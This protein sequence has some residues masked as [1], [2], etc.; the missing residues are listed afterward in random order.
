MIQV[1][2]P[3]LIEESPKF[4]EKNLLIN[5]KED[6]KYAAIVFAIAPWDFG[7]IYIKARDSLLLNTWLSFLNQLLEPYYPRPK[8]IPFN[9]DYNNLF[10]GVDLSRSLNEGRVIR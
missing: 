9:I 6:L 2:P 3:E 1:Q 5:T 10:G 7:G 4:S 8:K